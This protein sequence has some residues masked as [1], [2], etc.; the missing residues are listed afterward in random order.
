MRIEYQNINVQGTSIQIGYSYDIT[1]FMVDIYTPFGESVDEIHLREYLEE[2]LFPDDI[3]NGNLIWSILCEEETSQGMLNRLICIPQKEISASFQK[4]EYLWPQPLKSFLGVLQ[5]PVTVPTLYF[6]TS[7]KHFAYLGVEDQNILFCG[8]ESSVPNPNER[9]KQWEN[10][11]TQKPTILEA[12]HFESN[13]HKLPNFFEEIN[14][15]PQSH[16]IKMQQKKFWIHT[17]RVW[18]KT[19][20]ICAVLICICCGLQ[21]WFTY[22]FEKTKTIAAELIPHLDEIESLEMQIQTQNKGLQNQKSLWKKPISHYNNILL[23]SKILPQDGKL[24]SLKIQD[25]SY[26]STVE[27][28]NWDSAEKYQKDIE[29]NSFIKQFVF[30]KKSRKKNGHIRFTQDILF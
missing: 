28:K 12:N 13:L 30:S 26:K 25:S 5:A 22:N 3:C 9:L 1:S 18:L 27:L 7:D 14:V 21:F 10:Y 19:L 20:A 6:S 16:I 17:K 2:R 15:L 4:V 29:T 24:L 8:W 23:L 11:F